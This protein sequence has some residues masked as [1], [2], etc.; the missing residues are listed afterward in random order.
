[1]SFISLFP[2]LAYLLFT[3]AAW[4]F[5]IYS[6][7]YFVHTI[8]HGYFEFGIVV[9]VFLLIMPRGYSIIFGILIAICDQ[10][11]KKDESK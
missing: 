2:D 3:S 7:W 9:G 10:F 6:V 5:M 1:M 8:K 4:L 11:I